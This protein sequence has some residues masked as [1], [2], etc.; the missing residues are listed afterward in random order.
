[1]L[2]DDVDVVESIPVEGSSEEGTGGELI[3]KDNSD[4]EV[5]EERGAEWIVYVEMR[6]MRTY[7]LCDSFSGKN[8]VNVVLIYF[9]HRP[10]FCGSCE[11]SIQQ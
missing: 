5:D 1:M 9:G 10:E 2:R 11:L 3:D 8:I 7:K 4:G 6:I